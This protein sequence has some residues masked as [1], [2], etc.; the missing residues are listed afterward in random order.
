MTI[1]ARLIILNFIVITDQ[2]NINKKS[3]QR[4]YNIFMKQLPLIETTDS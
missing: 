3:Y 4:P 1:D 2:R